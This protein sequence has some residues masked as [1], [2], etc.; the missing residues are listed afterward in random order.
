MVVF[1]LQFRIWRQTDT[2]LNSQV[3]TI[4]T[5]KKLPFTKGGD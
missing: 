2:S 4:M 5:E 1:P 3:Y